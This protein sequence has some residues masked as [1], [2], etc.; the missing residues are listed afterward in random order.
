LDE[1]VP[2]ASPVQ[3]CWHEILP[4]VALTCNELFH[5]AI[6]LT[7]ERLGIRTQL[8][9]HAGYVAELQDF[10][11]AKIDRTIPEFLE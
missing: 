7:R 9:D 10:I 4:A 2:L 11:A 8:P 1:R 5:F 3:P 6:K